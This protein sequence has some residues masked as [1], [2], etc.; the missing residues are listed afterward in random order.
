MASYNRDCLPVLLIVAT[1]F[2]SNVV[3]FVNTILLL[4][5]VLKQLELVK[6]P[7]DEL[8]SKFVINWSK[9]YNEIKSFELPP[10]LANLPYRLLVEIDIK[11]RSSIQF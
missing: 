3:L 11:K 7:E 6:L 2:K 9:L 5:V 4:P 1:V 10:E 8:E